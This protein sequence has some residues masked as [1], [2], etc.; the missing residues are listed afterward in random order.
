V[1][2]ED[3]GPGFDYSRY[4]TLDES[5]VFDNHGRGIALAGSV[6]DLQFLGRGNKVLITIMDEEPDDTPQVP[7]SG[8]SHG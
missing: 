3:E 8:A 5:R 2:I 1:L 4:V 6:L 7:D